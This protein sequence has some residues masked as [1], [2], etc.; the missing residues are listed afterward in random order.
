[1]QLSATTIVSTKTVT[2]VKIKLC[3]NNEKVRSLIALGFFINAKL[4]DVIDN[5]MLHNYLKSDSSGWMERLSSSRLIEIVI[6]ELHTT[7]SDRK[8]YIAHA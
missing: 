4:D 8:R 1:M 5:F 6:N 7:K 3:G 2:A